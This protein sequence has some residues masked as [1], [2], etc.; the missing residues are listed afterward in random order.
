MR[1]RYTIS[2]LRNIAAN[3]LIENRRVS[4]FE[5]IK[6]YVTLSIAKCLP[7]IAFHRLCTA[8]ALDVYI[9]ILGQGCDDVG[10]KGRITS[11][12]SCALNAARTRS[13]SFAARQTPVRFFSEVVWGHVM[14][15]PGQSDRLGNYGPKLRLKG[16]LAT[17]PGSGEIVGKIG[18]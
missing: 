12:Y 17:H 10:T 13:V 1:H 9:V 16:G 4:T 14:Y 7:K 2:I 8:D 3:S 18:L 6:K 11:P 5:E 15:I